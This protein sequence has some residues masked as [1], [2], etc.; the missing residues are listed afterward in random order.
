MERTE[1]WH[2][3]KV[4]ARSS[5]RGGTWTEEPRLDEREVEEVLDEELG[6]D[7]LLEQRMER[8][9]GSAARRAHVD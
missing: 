6:V 1:E 2:V 5:A 8:A 4:G 9:R 3:G 7:E